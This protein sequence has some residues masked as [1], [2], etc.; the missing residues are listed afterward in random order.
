[1]YID[2]YTYIHKYLLHQ[3]AKDEEWKHIEA[4]SS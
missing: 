3:F 2:R 1:M 4:L